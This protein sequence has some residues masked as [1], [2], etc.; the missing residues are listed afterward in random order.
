MMFTEKKRVAAKAA[1]I[2]AMGS[3][4]FFFRMG[5]AM[6]MTHQDSDRRHTGQ[7]TGHCHAY[8]SV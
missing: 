7:H 4:R 5:R 2:T 3:Q 8:I 1:S 6:L